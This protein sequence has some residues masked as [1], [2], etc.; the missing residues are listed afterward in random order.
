MSTSRDRT[1]AR[2]A[3]AQRTIISGEQLLACGL[4]SDA[5][6][7]RSSTGRLTVVFRGVFSVVDG[8]LPTL[9]REQ[10]ALL[11]CGKGAFLSHNTAAFVWGVRKTPPALIEVSVVGRDIRS[12]DGLRIHRIQAID[13]REVRRHEGLWVSS[14]ARAVLE[15]AAVAPAELPGV[16][17]AG[18]HSGS[19]TAASSVVCSR[20]TGHVAGPPGWRRSWAT[21]TR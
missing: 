15:V 11:A 7:Y 16:I 1:I 6:T 2:I 18:W 20:A 5:I 14:P 4:G 21:R 17:D 3:G 13:R 8:E 9:A 10:A 19:S 12:R